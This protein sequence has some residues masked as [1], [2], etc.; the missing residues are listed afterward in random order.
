MFRSV[1]HFHDAIVMSGLD[2]FTV[3]NPSL[4]SRAHGSGLASPRI[5]PTGIHR[6]Y[7]GNMDPGLDPGDTSG[8]W[9]MV[10]DGASA[11][12]HHEVSVLIRPHPEASVF[13][14]P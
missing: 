2:G 4:S 9:P 11:P 7:Q 3:L 14:S 5:N 1:C 8:P 6:A 12:P 10:R 13:A